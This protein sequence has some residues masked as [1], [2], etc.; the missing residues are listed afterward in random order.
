[1]DLE[2]DESRIYELQDLSES[3]TLLLSTV[4]ATAIRVACQVL[5]DNTSLIYTIL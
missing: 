3:E 5:G 1:M 4:E 2:H